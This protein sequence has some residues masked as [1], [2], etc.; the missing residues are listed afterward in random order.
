MISAGSNVSNVTQYMSH[1]D[2]YMNHVIIYMHSVIKYCGYVTGDGRR[3][4]ISALAP[5]L[6]N[7]TYPTSHGCEG[8]AST[9][10]DRLSW[11]LENQPSGRESARELLR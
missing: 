7:R 8:C 2:I 11:D 10:T 6:Y 9:S 3:G 1:V 4:V 5:S